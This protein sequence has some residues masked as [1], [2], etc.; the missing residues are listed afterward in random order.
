MGQQPHQIRMAATLTLA[1]LL[2]GCSGKEPGWNNEGVKPIQ[3]GPRGWVHGLAFTPDSNYLVVSSAVN[4]RP[5]FAVWDVA[6]QKEVFLAEGRR[7]VI[8]F[9]PDGKTMGLDGGLRAKFSRD[10]EKL[11]AGP[12]VTVWDT[13]TW[14]EKARPAVA[15]VASV[16]FL[17]FHP[18]EDLLFV[19]GR[20]HP[21]IEDCVLLLW[22]LKAGKA[23]Y[24]KEAQKFLSSSAGLSPDGS[25][26]VIGGQEFIGKEWVGISGK[27]VETASGKELWSFAAHPTSEGVTH[28]ACVAFLPDGGTFATGGN[29]G[30]VRMWDLKTRKEKAVFSGDLYVSRQLAVSPDGKVIVVAGSNPGD[31]R[32]LVEFWEVSTGKRLAKLNVPN[33]GCVALSPDGKWLATGTADGTKKGGPNYPGAVHLWKMADVLRKKSE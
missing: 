32:G 14:K 28:I 16:D 3:V 12:R 21:R 7:E 17:A 23:R 1:L 6:S 26:L 15:D 24:R 2:L 8:A 4:K 5:R 20:S 9:S 33:V 30:K 11:E 18:K 19:A 27:V 29:D 10:D 22:D 31:V 13:T 25:T